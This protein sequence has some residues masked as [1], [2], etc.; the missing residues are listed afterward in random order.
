MII[1]YL[2]PYKLY[3]IKIS[4]SDNTAARQYNY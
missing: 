4:G 1:N 2:G 3:D